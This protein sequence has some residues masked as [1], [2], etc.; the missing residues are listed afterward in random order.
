MKLISITAQQDS[1]SQFSQWCMDSYLQLNMDKTKK[2]VIHTVKSPPGLNHASIQGQTVEQVSNFKYFRLIT[3]S[4][5]NLRSMLL[6][7]RNM[8][9]KDYMPYAN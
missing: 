5:L 8:H 4:N 1:V 6:R 3:D 2:L 9:D 7:P